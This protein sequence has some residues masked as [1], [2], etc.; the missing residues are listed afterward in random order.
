MSIVSRFLET[1]KTS[2]SFIPSGESQG[3]ERMPFAPTLPLAFL[4]TAVITSLPLMV[5]SSSLSRASFGIS[6]FPQTAACLAAFF[7]LGPMRRRNISVALRWLLS[8]AMLLV[9]ASL[10]VLEATYG[11]LRL[12][13][14]YAAAAHGNTTFEYLVE[15]GLYTV[16]WSLIIANAVFA[17]RGE[18]VHDSSSPRWAPG[19]VMLLFLVQDL[20]LRV[21]GLNATQPLFFADSLM[22]SEVLLFALHLGR[23]LLVMLAV[24]R[25]ASQLLMG[26]LFTSLTASLLTLAATT[27]ASMG[28]PAMHVPTQA[29]DLI[30]IAGFLT[31]ST[32]LAVIS[33]IGKRLYTTTSQPDSPHPVTSST[34][35]TSHDRLSALSPR[36]RK[37]IELTLSGASQKEIASMLG[38]S[39]PSVGTYR[40][41]SYRKLG[42]ADKD[43]LIN[44]F[45]TPEIRND[46]NGDRKT[47]R[48]ESSSVARFSPSLTWRTLR[49]PIG[50]L[51]VLQTA[52][53]VPLTIAITRAPWTSS[54]GLAFLAMTCLI[55]GITLVIA[56]MSRRDVSPTFESTDITPSAARLLL[57]MYGTFF[58]GAAV[59]LRGNGLSY[60]ALA[61]GY[62]ILLLT[63]GLLLL[64]CHYVELATAFDMFCAELY[65][66]PFGEQRVCHALASKGFDER[67]VE[68]LNKTLQGKTSS[69]IAREQ[70][71]STSS[72]RALRS[73]AYRAFGVHSK[74]EF[75]QSVKRQMEW[76]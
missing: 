39:V 74:A 1:H 63:E 76:G 71:M 4:C 16:G 52:G 70:L 75:A 72:V 33:A 28:A 30:A 29:A 14:S 43:S 20:C 6:G 55:L 5:N 51:A 22:T 47:P 48:L 9:V 13:E 21:L 60:T 23:A 58:L 57:L 38:I 45:Q 56:R 2:S 50:K 37:V 10:I 27:M 64:T 62:I 17:R 44:A 7:I 68:V 12:S 53:M 35:G 31:T 24:H 61:S 3:M 32:A 65:R 25:L 67:A 46:I 54:L 11:L 49:H 69:C 34:C 42:V 40:I 59:A 66:P 41:R 26:F 73:A 18:P 8:S 19:A 36:E 15:Q